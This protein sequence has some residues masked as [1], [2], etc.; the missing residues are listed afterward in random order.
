MPGRIWLGHPMRSPE[1]NRAIIRSQMRELGA[2]RMICLTCPSCKQERALTGMYRC[3]QCGIWFCDR[4]CAAAHWPEAAAARHSH[5]PISEH[6]GA[7]LTPGESEEG[8]V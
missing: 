8:A 6:D 5:M 1:E 3:Y 7:L 4:G 2:G